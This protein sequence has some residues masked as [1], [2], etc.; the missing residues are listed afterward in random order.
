MKNA[1]TSKR[2][3][4]PAAGW[5]KK[6]ARLLVLNAAKIFVVGM[7]LFLV[8]RAVEY[9]VVRTLRVIFTGRAG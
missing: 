2:N 1:N 3:V 6:N 5:L 4:S 7:L 9:M 8:G